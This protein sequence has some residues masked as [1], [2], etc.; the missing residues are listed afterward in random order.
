MRK[1]IVAGNWKMNHNYDQATGFVQ[2]LLPQLEVGQNNRVEMMIAPSF[3][4]VERL[5]TLTKNTKLMIGCQDI[6][7]EEKGAFT[8]EVSAG[9][10][11]S[12]KGDFAIIGHSERREYH[13]ESNELIKKKLNKLLEYKI[14]PIVCIGET[15]EQRE[16]GITKD[17]ILS[18]LD[19]CFTGIDLNQHHE[20]IIAYEPVWAIGTGKTATPE[21]AEEVHSMIRAWLTSHYSRTT[22][23]AIHIL[24]GGS[25][26][27]ANIKSLVSQPN[28]D[29][30]LIGGAA[31]KVDSYLEMI[32]IVSKL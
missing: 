11:A 15:L 17:V 2:E 30:G 23:E 4:F 32:K 25:M 20:V 8:G 9:M 5:L 31:L 18:Q 12:I 29:G 22:A 1:I 27:P 6:S 10:L 13:H 14:R 21:M 7:S 3:L 19:G 28:I 24:Y 16:E 26:K